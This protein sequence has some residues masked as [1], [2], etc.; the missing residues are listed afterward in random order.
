MSDR[1]QN[2]SQGQGQNPHVICFLDSVWRE[3]NYSKREYIEN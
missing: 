1:C 2:Y 3:Q